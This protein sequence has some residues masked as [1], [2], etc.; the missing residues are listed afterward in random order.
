MP[1]GL[2]T[3]TVL[4]S[5][6]RT[7]TID[8]APDHVI[9]FVAE[10]G[11]L[12]AWAVGFCRAIRPAE[13]PGTWIVTTAQGEMP[14]RFV[15]NEQLGT[16]DFYFTP[17]PGAEAVAFSRVVPNGTGA[18]Y[19][20]TQFQPTGMPDEVFDAQVHALAEELQVLRALIHARGACRT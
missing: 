3:S 7:V 9:A 16:I 6:T 14:I 19:I 20:F 10:A 2:S 15:A 4:R 12:P 17:A 1:T 8:A 5:D 13:E 18:E 11:N